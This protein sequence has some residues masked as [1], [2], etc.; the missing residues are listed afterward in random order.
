MTPRQQLSTHNSHINQPRVHQEAWRPGERGGYQPHPLAARRPWMSTT[1][2]PWAR[3]ST[4]PA[5]APV[6][7]PARP[8]QC[9]HHQPELRRINGD[10][11]RGSSA[12]CSMNAVVARSFHGYLYSAATWRVPV[13]SCGVVLASHDEGG[14][15]R[16]AYYVI[17]GGCT[18]YVC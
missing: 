8:A 9:C 10:R 2:Q 7:P 17:L 13:P 3:G 4:G 5:S 16:P 1:A 6:L 12:G 11:A 15:Q 14:R 18:R